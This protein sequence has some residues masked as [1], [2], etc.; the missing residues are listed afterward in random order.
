MQAYQ[1]GLLNQYF[2]WDLAPAR[3]P[4]NILVLI[5][6]YTL[7]AFKQTHKV[8]PKT[9]QDLHEFFQLTFNFMN[10]FW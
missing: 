9:P 4:V 5:T 6:R 3:A 2:Q 7:E 10:G 1:Q 8:R